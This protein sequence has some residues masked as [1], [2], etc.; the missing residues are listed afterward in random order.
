MPIT[1]LAGSTFCTSDDRGDVSGPSAGLF[2]NDTRFLSRLVLCVNGARPLLLIGKRDDPHAAGFYTRNPLAGGLEQDELAVLRRRL[3]SI[4]LE[5][6][7]VVRNLGGRRLDV[8][9]EL[10]IEADFADISA[11]KRHDFTLGEPEDGPPLP[12]PAPAEYDG[13]RPGS[14]TRS[15]SSRSSRRSA[16]S[17]SA[18]PPA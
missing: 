6:H 11:V 17:A 12:H 4:G 7:I 2:A 3:V 14:R 9:V 16:D 10:A 8:D 1:I 15:R 5:E 13:A 18:S